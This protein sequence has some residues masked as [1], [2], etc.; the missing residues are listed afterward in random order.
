MM[1][2]YMYKAF[3]H[4]ASIYANLL[5]HKKPFTWEEFNSHKIAKWYINMAAV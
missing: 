1:F 2:T 5:E 3:I 4:M